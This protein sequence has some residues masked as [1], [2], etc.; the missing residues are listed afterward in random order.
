[1]NTN[2]LKAIVFGSF[3]WVLSPA[4]ASTPDGQTPAQEDVCDGLVD[5][6]YGTC[7]A[8]CEAMDCD[9]PDT[10]ASDKACANKIKKWEQLVGND[11]PLPCVQTG[12]IMLQKAINLTQPEVGSKIQYSFTITN[13]GTSPLKNII[14]EDPNIPADALD[15]CQA[16]LFALVLEVNEAFKCATDADELFAEAGEVTNTATVTAADSNDNTVFDTDSVT[17]FGLPVKVGC[18]C[19]EV[20][21]NNQGAGNDFEPNTCTIVRDVSP[22][23]LEIFVNGADFTRHFTIE[24]G[25][26]LQ[27]CSDFALIFTG[28]VIIEPNPL[29]VAFTPE[30]YST[31]KDLLLTSG[32]Y[33]TSVNP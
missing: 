4:M 33:C 9:S 17:Y 16:S 1:M 2:I 30:E 24:N 29:A 19:E 28:E 25:S 26:V 22:N 32:N 21:G 18:P 5:A 3:C 8:Y 6:E 12:S 20:W 31:C 14:I 13:D 27:V 10:K 23:S 15:D 11:Q 7:V